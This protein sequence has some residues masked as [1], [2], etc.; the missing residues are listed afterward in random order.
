MTAKGMSSRL[1]GRVKYQN[2]P[3]RRDIN[4]GFVLI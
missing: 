2:I 3:H 4:G 1:V